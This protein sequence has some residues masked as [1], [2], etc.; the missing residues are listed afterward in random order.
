MN[1]IFSLIVVAL[2]LV[3]TGSIGCSGKSPNGPGTIENSGAPVSFTPPTYKSLSVP[4]ATL[5]K[6]T[7]VVNRFSING[8]SKGLW[9]NGFNIEVDYVMA[10]IERLEIYVYRDANFSVNALDNPIVVLESINKVG[11]EGNWTGFF[12]SKV[13]SKGLNIEPFENLYFETRMTVSKLNS[14]GGGSFVSTNIDDLPPV[15]LYDGKTPVVTVKSP[16][17][18]PTLLPL[19]GVI[20]IIWDGDVPQ[21]TYISLTN[22]KGNP[23]GF[24]SSGLGDRNPLEKKLLWDSKSQIFVS[25]NDRTPIKVSEG[26]YRIVFS[27]FNKDGSISLAVSNVFTLVTP[28]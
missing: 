7:L 17:D 8:G 4:Y 12:E 19:G 3:A 21:G 23:V 1:K 27:F 10:E 20:P 22:E 6:G 11:V 28:G 2:F 25:D 26:K 24:I 16:Y 15:T 13:S 5:S 18:P 14:W 9:K